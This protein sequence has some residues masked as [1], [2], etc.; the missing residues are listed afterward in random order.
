MKVLLNCMRGQWE[1]AGETLKTVEMMVGDKEL[2]RKVLNDTV[3]HQT[4][5]TPLMFAAIENN[6]QFM[7]R[8]VALGCNVNKKNK[9]GYIALHFAVM[10]SRDDIVSWLLARKSNAN[11]AAGPMQQT[12]LHLA[13]ARHSGHSL[14]V[15]IKTKPCLA[16]LALC[17]MVSLSF[18]FSSN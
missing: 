11:L 6:I 13:S 17:L 10:Y 7:E 18:Y 16:A 4:G 2:D 5:N 3:D 14:Q 12:C 15:S 8:L 1:S 9:E